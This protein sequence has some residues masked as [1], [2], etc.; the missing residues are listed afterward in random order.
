MADSAAWCM[1]RTTQHTRQH[2]APSTKARPGNI[3]QSTLRY[4][5]QRFTV[6]NLIIRLHSTTYIHM[7]IPNSHCAPTQSAY[8]HTSSH[9]NRPNTA[10]L[11]RQRAA[12]Q[13]TPERIP[14]P[15]RA[16][17][18][19]HGTKT[20]QLWRMSDIIVILIIVHCGCPECLPPGAFLQFTMNRDSRNAR[21]CLAQS[22]VSCHP[23]CLQFHR[24]C[25]HLPSQARWPVND[26]VQC[27]PTTA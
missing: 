15:P 20:L 5:I 11:C 16:Q 27:Q 24:F 9:T 23:H 8:M 2:H 13:H 4:C 22:Q 7:D 14:S 17:C 3:R 21:D 12:R 25:S 19:S 18:H 6:H 1:E 26:W 10:H